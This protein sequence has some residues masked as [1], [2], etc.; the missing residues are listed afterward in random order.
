MMKLIQVQGLLIQGNQVLFGRQIQNQFNRF[1][2]AEVQT[3]SYH[4]AKLHNYKPLEPSKPNVLSLSGIDS[5]SKKTQVKSET[6]GPTNKTVLHRD[7]Q[8]ITAIRRSLISHFLVDNGF[9]KTA[10]MFKKLSQKGS[11][12]SKTGK[13]KLKKY[14]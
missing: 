12:T 10:E 5:R 11:E 4:R 8:I 1:K 6:N 2:V 9:P 14:L 13:V 7:H 3:I